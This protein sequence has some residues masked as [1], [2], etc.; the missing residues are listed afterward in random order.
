MEEN[1]T[2]FRHLILFI[3]IKKQKTKNAVQTAN[4]KCTVYGDGTVAEVTGFRSGNFDLENCDGSGRTAVL[5]M[6]IS[7]RRLKNIGHTTSDIA[8]TLHI[9]HMSVLRALNSCI[10]ESIVS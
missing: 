10:S 3:Y 5:M 7:E 9:S 4:N 6:T 2:Y 1:E 8:E